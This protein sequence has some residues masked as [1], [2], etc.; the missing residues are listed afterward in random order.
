MFTRVIKDPKWPKSFRR[1]L[2]KDYNSVIVLL[3][4]LYIYIVFFIVAI[5]LSFAVGRLRPT[6][7]A[8]RRPTVFRRRL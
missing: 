1:L 8:K 5:L 4:A 3:L 7:A 2:A 6:S